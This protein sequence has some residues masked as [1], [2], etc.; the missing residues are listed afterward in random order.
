MGTRDLSVDMWGGWVMMGCLVSLAGCAV[1]PHTVDQLVGEQHHD[2]EGQDTSIPK[3]QTQHIVSE[4]ISTA[5]SKSSSSSPSPAPSPVAPVVLLPPPH[6][7]TEHLDNK[8]L[9]VGVCTAPHHKAHREAIRRTWA[10]MVHNPN[11][12]PGWTSLTN[13]VDVR[14]FIGQLPDANS[15]T[16]KYLENQIETESNMHKDIVRLHSF[17]E[18]YENLTRKSLAMVQW[19]NRH[20]TISYQM[21]MKVDDDTFVLLDQVVN[22]IFLPDPDPVT[23]WWGKFWGDENSPRP[24]DRNPYSKYYLSRDE[25]APETFPDYPDG[26]CYAVGRELMGWLDYHSSRLPFY[27]LEDSAMGLWINNANNIPFRPIQADAYMYARNCPVGMWYSFVNPV[28]PDEMDGMF[29]NYMRGQDICDG[30]FTLRVCSDPVR[31]CLCSPTLPGVEGCWDKQPLAQ[32][33]S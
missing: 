16:A 11:H 3:V 23:I 13:Q 14:F 19:A 1:L 18:S 22:D 32:S 5:P 8:L 27:R 6:S 7:G 21:M 2:A 29:S 25:Y 20:P 17:V 9:L 26:P 10:S 12:L 15:T 31:G 30:N 28:E 4:F 24:V 33:W